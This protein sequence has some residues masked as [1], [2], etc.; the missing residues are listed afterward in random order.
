MPGQSSPVLGSTLATILVA[1]AAGFLATAAVWHPAL[2]QRASSR[3]AF[4]AAVGVAYAG[5][6]LGLW[7][8]VRVAAHPAPFSVDVGSTAVWLA[9]AALGAVA[10]GGGTAYVYDRYRY[11]T[12]L[13]AVLA[14]TAFT[15]YVFLDTAGSATALAIWGLVYVPVFVVAAAASLVI[16]W[17]VRRASGSSDP[18]TPAA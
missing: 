6:T 4:A 8:A 15:W 2:R 11:V 1:G 12:A 16:E 18:E 3:R 7:T 14:A 5:L 13:F 9:L 10:V 17:G